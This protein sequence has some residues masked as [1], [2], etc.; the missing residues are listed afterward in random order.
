MHV[1]KICRQ[2]FKNTV[3]TFFL[4]NSFVMSA[5][6]IKSESHS[7]AVSPYEILLTKYATELKPYEERL[8]ST[9]S[10]LYHMSSEEDDLHEL[11]NIRVNLGLLTDCDGSGC[12]LEEKRRAETIHLRS[13]RME[14]DL[15]EFKTTY[16]HYKYTAMVV[17]SSVVTTALVIVPAMHYY[18][19]K[20]VR[21][22]ATL[23]AEKQKILRE[24]T[25]KTNGQ[26]AIN[27]Q[28]IRHIINPKSSQ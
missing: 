18:K 16:S 7:P 6:Q 15:R 11:E 3:L 26:G 17:T 20:A 21:S 22:L 14:N 27:K 1:F 28:T 9:F 5:Q 12:T 2:V 10:L 8:Q 13:L 4:L 24:I 23:L 25:E 19:K